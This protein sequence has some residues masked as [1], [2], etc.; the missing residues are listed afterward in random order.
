MGTRG[1]PDIYTLALGHWVYTYIRQTTLAHVITYTCSYKISLLC[2]MVLFRDQFWQQKWSREQFWDIFLVWLDQ[3]QGDRFWCDSQDS[4]KL[5]TFFDVRNFHPNAR[6]HCHSSIPSMYWQH[7]LL[8]RKYLQNIV[9][10]LQK[11]LM[12]Y[13]TWWHFLT[14]AEHLSYKT[15]EQLT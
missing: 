14:N 7:E 3:F 6:S 12:L 11:L 13:K 5:I 15:M 4:T 8:K 1:L 2:K 9:G 10:R